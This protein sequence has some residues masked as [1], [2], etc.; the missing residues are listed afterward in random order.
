MESKD[1]KNA[2][3]AVVLSGLILF[4]WNY[5]FEPKTYV[6]TEAPKKSATDE[7]VSEVKK[8]ESVNSTADLSNEV[9]FSSYKLSTSDSWVVIDNSLN[10]VDFKFKNAQVSLK[11]N[12][13]KYKNEVSFI[14]DEVKVNPVFEFNQ[15]ND[16]QIDISDSKSGFK[17]SIKLLTDGSLDILVS[18]QKS[19]SSIIKLTGEKITNEDDKRKSNSFIYYGSSLEKSIVGSDDNDY[20]EYAFKWFGLDYNYHLFSFVVDQN[21]ISKISNN[22]NVLTYRTLKNSN[23]L[24]FKVVFAKKNYDDLAKL[25][26]ELKKSVDFG[27]WAIIAVPI[28]RGLQF[29]FDLTK[30][31]GLAIIILTIVIRLLTFPLQYKSF[32]SMKKMQVIQPELQKIREKHK[33]NPQKMQ[34]ETMALFKK[35]G[36]N[37][38]SG[39]LPMLA[40]MPIFFAFY[41]VLFTSVELVDAPFYFWIHDLSQK[42]PF[43]ILPVL[44]GVA[45]FLNMKLTPSTTA[46]PAQ[47]KMMMFMPII[48]SVF[49]L[50][51]PSGLT[52]YMLISTLMGMAQQLFVYRQTA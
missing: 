11:E 20:T 44:M 28:L 43:Y 23:K 9:V 24:N 52:L 33:E 42:D 8:S 17:G 19:F 49:M 34:Q 21:D 47:Q 2:I 51:L 3:L 10:I 32:K 46:D 6:K 12:F 50:S 41:Q 35:A 48:F 30:N 38:L 5:F 31:Y 39:C 14:I 4:G 45:M 37:P 40:Q 16:G 22:S 27:M 7:K 29:F 25:G 15:V 18:N 13:K 1:N 26:H 36:A